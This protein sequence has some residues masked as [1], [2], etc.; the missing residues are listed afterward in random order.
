[1]KNL[2]N[3]GLSNIAPEKSTIVHSTAIGRRSFGRIAD[4][5]C[6]WLEAEAQFEPK[7]TSS[8]RLLISALLEAF[9]KKQNS[10]TRI[11]LA[12]FEGQ[13]YVALR[14]ECGIDV[15]VNQ[16]ERSFTQ[17]W[18]NSDEP[19]LLKKI[20]HAAD[21]IEV[22]Y[23]QKSGLMEWRVCRPL[24]GEIDPH[25][26]GSFL[27][28]TDQREDFHQ[29]E[30]NYRDLGD[31]PYKKWLEDVYRS[32]DEDSASGS[33]L[34][35]GEETQANVDLSRVKVGGEIME[36]DEHV[37]RL[38]PGP[39][40]APEN[41]ARFSGKEME[42]SART[43]VYDDLLQ[44]IRSHENIEADLLDRLDALKYDDQKKASQIEQ[45]KA[46]KL[47]MVELLNKKQ[48]EILRREAECKTLRFKVKQ[49]NSLPGTESEGAAILFRDKA[50]EMYHKL[51]GVQAENEELQTILRQL[52]NERAEKSTP[53]SEES[54]GESTTIRMST[55]EIEKKLERLQRTLDAEKAKVKGLLDRTLA[56]EKESQASAPII[57]DLEAKVEYQLKT[58]IQYKKEIDQLKQK[59]V[60][61]DAE[62]NKV[63]NELIKAQ[64]QIQTLN[65]RLA[66]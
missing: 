57:S 12:T 30:A 6:A 50:I 22:R 60:Q 9:P 23:Q 8:L 36:I 37:A 10:S 51:K 29:P 43:G 18:L 55:E 42:S 48:R 46:Q 49:K 2:E 35:E 38:L 32:A 34:I 11:E 66:G 33:I 21:R 24:S 54:F 65:K 40:P 1:M 59:L 17:F 4:L 16:V 53:E 39:K 25:E 41:V 27:V 5:F 52:R 14:A 47:S 56:A 19:Q 20:L 44:K 26:S 64:A 15:D 3:I 7:Q 28:F 58:S 31:T 61:A 63:K 13:V 62:K 45:L